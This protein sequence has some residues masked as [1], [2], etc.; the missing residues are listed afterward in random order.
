[1]NRSE[2]LK[3]ISAL[4]LLLTASKLKPVERSAITDAIVVGGG[5]SGLYLAYLLNKSG[6]PTQVLES[7]ARL[8]G[9]IF[10][11]D[12]QGKRMD[13]GG[14]WFSVKDSDLVSLIKEM[15][16]TIEYVKK[17]SKIS[18]ESKEI[19]SKL[20]KLFET[21]NSKSKESL[22]KLNILDYLEYQ[23]ISETDLKLL[24]TLLRSKYG[25][26]GSSV[27]TLQ[28]LEDHSKRPIVEEVL[29]RI[30]GGTFQLISRLQESISENSI[31]LNETVTSLSQ[32]TGRVSIGLASGAKLS[33]SIV[34]VTIPPKS[35]ANF[36][37]T[38][39]L[40]REK[41]LAILQTTMGNI[42]KIP[43]VVNQT[44]LP[45]FEWN[46]SSLIEELSQLDVDSNVF[47]S[48]AYGEKSQALQVAKPEVLEYIV[49]SSLSSSNPSVAVDVEK[50]IK[51]PFRKSLTYP[52]A[53]TVFSLG[54][55]SVKETFR[56]P[57]GKIYFAGD[58]LGDST[59]TMNGAVQ[60]AIQAFNQIGNG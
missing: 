31:R 28:V 50:I 58:T 48:Q 5:L 18:S 54:S 25:V 57:F 42:S 27:S 4:G 41:K 21:M 36:A 40:P 13:L 51:S 59:G 3:S 11:H 16:L 38:P 47:I 37:W 34:F 45:S 15:G 52:G 24:N 32:G 6:I 17:N 53:K 12:E 9:R 46:D 55:S 30:K 35:F 22:A 8:G 29:G 10:T 26:D 7:N 43:F 44:Y 49:K 19:I 60:S 2:F 33:S 20:Q 1:M 56:L 39:A 23:G 14:E